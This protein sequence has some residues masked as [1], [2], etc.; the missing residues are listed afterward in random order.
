LKTEH[1]KEIAFEKNGFRILKEAYDELY[2]SMEKEVRFRDSAAKYTRALEE[3]FGCAILT[4]ENLAKALAA[5]AERGR[6]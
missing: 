5:L 4:A 1:G 2:E 6:A 3:R